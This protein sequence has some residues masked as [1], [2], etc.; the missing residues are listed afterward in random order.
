MA[1]LCIVSTCFSQISQLEGRI[2]D[3][4]TGARIS[5]ATIQIVSTNTLVAS[6]LE[7]RFKLNLEVGKSYELTISSV[8]Y[9]TKRIEDV[10]LKVGQTPA[11]EITLDPS[12][13]TE[14]AVEVR[15]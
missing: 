6:D 11:L 5:S 9:V 2:T 15:S 3:A 14:Q 8:S 4:S 12:R 7:G 13:K 10:K 1:S